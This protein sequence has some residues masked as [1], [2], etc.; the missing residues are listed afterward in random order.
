MPFEEY[1]DE[2][3]E[4]KSR[5]IAPEGTLSD[6]QR[7]GFQDN[8]NFNLASSIGRTLAQGGRDFVQNLYDSAYDEIATYNPFG[9]TDQSQMM[10][11]IENIRANEGTDLSAKEFNEL[12]GQRREELFPSD[13]PGVLGKALNIEPTSFEEPDADIP[14]LGK[15]LPN[16]AQNNA[17]MMVGGLISSI[18]QFAL[19]AKGLKARGV[20][21]PKIPLYKTRM[22]TKLASN[23]PG[24]KGVFDRVEGRFIRGAQE[25]WLPGFI[26][27]V[28]IEDPWDGNM[29]NLFTGFLPE[30]KI[31]NLFN[32]FA[33]TEDDTLASARL[34]NGIVGTLLAGPLL[35]GGL[36]QLGGIKRESKIL[37]ND[38]NKNETIKFARAFADYFVK[39][40]NLAKKSNEARGNGNPLKELTNEEAKNVGIVKLTG[41][42]KK[43]A[44]EQAVE[45]I[46][47]QNKI[48]KNKEFPGTTGE[49]LT[50]SDITQ[51]ELDFANALVELDQAKKNL[52]V[53]ASRTKLIAESQGGIDET[54]SLDLQPVSGS[55]LDT[56]SVD[57]ISVDP[58]RLQFKQAGQTPT[59]QSG[60]LV[61]KI[62]KYNTDL[63]GVI[64]VWK[65]PAN[66]KI[67]VV[68]GHNRLAAAKLHQV[69]TINVRYIDSPNAEGAR[70]IGAMQNIAEGNGTGIDAAKIIR[71]TKM[72]AAEMI[73]QGIS[74][75]GAV[76]RK[77]IPLSKL[78]ASLFDEVAAQRMTEDMGAAIG[79][80]NSSEQVMID[81]AKAAKKKGWS[82][83]KTAEAASIA[84]FAKVSEGVDPNALP[85]PGFDTLITSN[86]ENI[87]NIR[88]A[89][90][91]QLR[92]EINALAVAANAKKAG[93]LESVGNIIDVDAS[94]TARDNSVQGELI[95]N[96]LANVSGPIND[97]I[98]DLASQITATKRAATVVQANIKKIRNAI[99]KENGLIVNAKPV[100]VKKETVIPTEEI[101]R[102]NPTEINKKPDLKK[103]QITVEPV[104]VGTANNAVEPELPRS[105]KQKSGGI[106]YRQ[107]KVFFSN[108]IDYAAYVVTKRRNR[109][110][111]VEMTGGSK[112][113]QKY[114]SFLMDENGLTE[115]DILLIANKQYE[116]LAADYIP[117]SKK[118]YSASIYKDLG[119]TS[120]Q[121]S[122]DPLNGINPIHKRSYGTLGNDYS[123]ATLLNYREKFELLEEIQRMAGENI[124]VQFV[125]ELEGTLTAK[126]A[127]DYGLT[128]G[129]T[130]SAAGE[131]IAGKNP[132]DDLIMISMFSK[133]GYRGFTKLLRTAFHESFHR[134]QKRLLS[135][136]DQKALIAGEKEI[137]ELA[138]KTMPEFRE[139]I[140]DGTIGRQE[141]EAIAF[142]DWY[143]RNT[144]YPKATWAEPFKKIAQIIERTGNFLKGRGYQTWDDVF[145]RAMRGEIAENADVNN[146][147]A[148]ATQ[149]AIDP[150]D[151]EK[152]ANEIKNN[153][154]A[155]NN[156]DISIEDAL[157]NQA[158]DE[159]R[160][161]VSRSGKTQYIETPNEVLAASYKAFN[162]IIY[163][164]TFN[165]ADATGIASIDTSMLFNQAVAKV[166]EA[167]GDSDALINSVERALKGDL[168]EANDLIG[169]ASLQLQADIVRNKT[170]IQSQA[171]LSASDSEKAVELQK[172]KVMLGEQLKLDL[173]YMSVMRKSG[174][175][176]SIGKLMFKADDVDLV[177]LPSEVTLYKGTSNLTGANVLRD[178][179]DV[180][181]E[182]GAMGQG[183]YF[184]TDENSIRVM[185]GYENTELYGDLINDIKILDLSGMNKRLTDLVNDLGLGKVKKTKNG[186][187]LNPEQIEAIKAYLL[188][189][190]YA[191]IRYEPRDT[192][193][194][195]PPA[196]EVVIFDNNSANRVV[197][198]DASV[199]PA[200]NPETP[201]KTLLEQAIAKSEDL[202]NDKLDPKLL[203]AIESGEL[204][205]EAIELGDVMVAISNY[206]QKNRSFNTHIN[207]L[208]ESTPK[209]GLTQRRLLNYYRGAIL[210]SGETVWKMMIG[211]LYRAATLPVVQTMGGFTRGV[212]QSIS[213]NKAEAY[214][215]FRRARLG[216]MLYGQYYQNLGNA[217]RLM[218]ATLR[219]NETFGN[220][221]VDQMQLR[222]NSRY[223]P[224]DQLSLGS[225]EVQMRKKNDIWHADPLGKNF[226]ANAA[227]RVWNLGNA[228]LSTVPKATGR[229]AGGVDTF[230][231]S[232]VGPSMEYVRFLDQELYH[233][234][235][236]LGMRP[237]SKEAFD[238][239]SAR[240]VELV[241]AEMVDV[242]LANGKKI[243]NAALTGQNA[244][245]IMDWV[246]F[247]DSLEV[248]PA[249]R[250]YEY[251]VR[252]ARE[253]GITDP[254][255]VHNFANKY[256][257]EGS[258]IFNEPVS[259]S[260]S[261]LAAGAAKVSQAVGFVPKVLGNVVENFPAF[262]L[263]YPL[264]R[265]PINI[266]K[267][268]ARAFPLSA[269]FID[270]FWRDITSEDLFARDRA[271]GEMALG[272]TTLAGGIALFSTG[273]VEFTGFRSMNYRDRETGPES[274]QRGRQP[275][276]IRFKNPFS[277][278]EEWT[279]YY[280]LQALD[281]LSNI[282]GAIGEY[283][284]VGNSLTEEE[285]EIE[286]SIVALK[287]AHVA[288]Q[289]GSGQFSKQILSS[290]TELFD[291]L[292]GWDADAA[293][294]MKKGKT[295][296]FSRYIE[297]KL[298]AF[299]PA[300][301]RKMNT[302]EARRDIVPSELPFPFNIFPNT[303]QRIQL[304]IPGA[305]E[306][307]PPVLHDYSGDVV[308]DRDY[309]GTSAI[310]KDMPWLKHFYKL[311][312]PTSSFHS[313]TK[314]TTAVDVELSK[315]YGKGSNYKPWNENIFNL[316]DR[317]L[318][319]EELNRL[320][321]IGTKE[322][323]N[324]S[325][326]TLMEELTSLITK[327]SVYASQ[328][329]IV[330]RDVEGPRMTMI[331][332][333]VKQ[334]KEKAKKKFLE[335]RP[336]IKLLIEQRDQKI[337]D[338]Q[339]TRDR[340]NTI[341]DKQSRNQSKLFLDQLNN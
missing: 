42:D 254:V 110:T 4:K 241:K 18:A 293:R 320:K 218:G 159:P 315:L 258:N 187:E 178:G 248:V 72:G 149:L 73:E 214:K 276:S 212:G 119:I 115:Q 229:L 275:M 176:L 99:A 138:A 156:G 160:R 268:S 206:S 339:Y 308:L 70:V 202:L 49:Q 204:T 309:A 5:Y 319:I 265:G 168:K 98:N 22:K 262:G 19:I 63:A 272:T 20:N 255:D 177:D 169:I 34:K 89:I 56:I 274:I 288:N 256:I 304:Q 114:L 51:K 94:K 136:A 16:I 167:G 205:E 301:I 50:T 116:Q 259:L 39:G 222:S 211:G 282:F 240:A 180:T 269:P 126:Q 79:S 97:V 76:M 334:F 236:V 85:L 197:G 209:G 184:T 33:V 203:D 83:N 47:E 213:G 157:K 227:L 303:A 71:E 147:S 323:R 270:T 121:L 190:G 296:A 111:V 246:N 158:L 186:L 117:G 166:K 243:E 55:A 216:A 337:I 189:R 15:P 93:T 109:R 277:D 112:N 266:L 77:A 96:K 74:P 195:N 284:E 279:P 78:P 273:L 171:Y 43:S 312:T 84:Q 333:V 30:G 134:I 261:G 230:M 183:V 145:E 198:S 164:L 287:I 233:A 165:R 100:T 250:T 1:T 199:I 182:T 7:E 104:R 280:S 125:R 133:G 249:P 131:F 27:D 102:N 13:Q 132:A 286:S 231:S 40:A 153:I 67:Y 242:T 264:P 150:P 252:K 32:E 221:G 152:I 289:L 14:F 200:A 295:G 192:G 225:D 281:T 217:F 329:Y 271:I 66:G 88:I 290:V 220:L 332:N 313:R 196:D 21:V 170:G 54:K 11:A 58:V 103:V 163:N 10:Q 68:N 108:D 310:P 57:D 257:N 129:D 86:F 263:I 135:K 139:S 294:R 185:D 193:R 297:R 48:Q 3:G 128:E 311:I 140:L 137:R 75:S 174:Q 335:E 105:L 24:V 191:G 316:P 321:I 226:F 95:F 53:T 148:P 238:Y 120:G 122:L 87:L 45:L 124:N 64:S 328:P 90:R 123:G 23:A 326:N 155:I 175:R 44:A 285:K 52:E 283:I 317:V 2:N 46:E 91:S 92:S 322:I 38:V 300:V 146:I 127:K 244:R 325:G 60:S 113:N 8:D 12:L 154:D 235:T 251:G 201:R 237:G 314:S 9:P 210:L 106:N 219:E 194:P 307:L 338:K 298:S 327:D 336:D 161:L 224:V 179:F 6:K 232:L 292:A 245:Y 62:A 181:Q 107:M 215:S 305:R 162:D 35:G 31:K 173:A 69:K 28:A 260:G 17:E 318:N 81:L 65:D 26:N 142:S 234:E 25:G 80:S 29:V 330:S 82:A 144:D 253:S 291:V 172:L 36:E 118:Q 267:A 61:G 37:F 341:N 141:A 41:R 223:N 228:A 143:L 188:D 302:G 151:P 207:D 247:T 331:K 306:E 59:G 324:E 299:M 208:I 278:S 239:A 340:L 101:V 130:Y